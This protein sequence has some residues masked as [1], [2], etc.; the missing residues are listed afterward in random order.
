M[1]NT[2]EWSSCTLSLASVSSC[3]DTL[4]ARSVCSMAALI[5]S[6][7]VVIRPFLRSTIA[8]C[9]FRSSFSL[10]ASSK[11]S[12]ESFRGDSTFCEAQKQ[13]EGMAS[14][15]LVMLKYPSTSCKPSLHVLGLLELL[16]ALNRV[17]LVFG[18]PLGHF[19]V[20]LGQGSLQLPLGLLLLLI[21]FPE[22]VTVVASGLQG[23]LL[24]A[25]QVVD[26][27][28]QLSCAVRVLLAQGGSRG[29]VLQRG[30][31]QV[32]AH[33]LEFCLAL[34]VHLHLS[35]C[36]SSG[37]FQ[38]LADLLQ[39]P[40]QVDSLL[41]RLG[42]DC[43]FGLNFLLQFLYPSLVY[44]HNPKTTY[45]IHL[46][47]QFGLGFGEGAD[48]VFLNLQIIQCLLV[49]FLEGLFLLEDNG[50]EEKKNSRER[51]R[52]E[53]L[54]MEVTHRLNLELQLLAVID[55]GNRDFSLAHVEEVIGVGG[56]QEE[57]CSQH[58]LIGVV[59]D[60][61][62]VWRG[63][64]ALLASVA[65]DH[66]GVVHR[67]PLV[68]VDSDAEETRVDSALFSK[69]LIL[70]NSFIHGQCL[71]FMNERTLYWMQKMDSLKGLQQWV[72]TD[73]LIL[74][75]PLKQMSSCRDLA[76]QEIG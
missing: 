1:P 68:G 17:R 41:F 48:F 72:G 37:F 76:H 27:L 36:G 58:E 23:L 65:S 11:W 59:R 70:K 7:S 64:L 50:E 34:L 24:H 6:I 53:N 5:S 9:S 39:L 18:S 63:L 26:L 73:D 20:G 19:T 47:L 30:L 44:I 45:I 66:L 21:L 57:I 22:Q 67:Q 28:A 51:G 56:D 55:A 43:T 32:T 60:G 35:C 3:S 62:D 52:G 25:L 15:A 71:T 49:G 2:C 46:L 16:R 12:W 42:T 74:K 33:L 13:A 8:S 40:G 61:E 31:F 69:G 14:S 29:F 54:E 10:K 4:R 75:C 38:A